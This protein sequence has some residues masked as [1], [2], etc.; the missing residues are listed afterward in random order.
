MLLLR[1]LGW[2]SEY[3]RLTCIYK[4][5]IFKMSQSFFC[6]KLP[7]QFPKSNEIHNQ[8]T[9]KR[10]VFLAFL[11]PRKMSFKSWLFKNIPALREF[12]NDGQKG[13]TKGQL[14]CSVWV[15]RENTSKIHVW[16]WPR[17]KLHSSLA[18]E[19]KNRRIG[20]ND[21]SSFSRKTREKIKAKVGNTILSQ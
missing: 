5:V 11:Q 9:C 20:N 7:K 3:P 1:Y 13:Q 18:D 12:M 4:S 16:T 21:D 10:T 15:F 6:T 19:G 17:A 8:I 14:L 2:R